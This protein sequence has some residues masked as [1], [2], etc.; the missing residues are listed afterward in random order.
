MRHASFKASQIS[1]GNGIIDDEKAYGYSV[2]A[3]KSLK[4]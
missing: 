3:Q 1:I 4:D 2:M